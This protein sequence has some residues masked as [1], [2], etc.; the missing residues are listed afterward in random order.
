MNWRIAFA[1]ALVFAA[2]GVSYGLAI[3]GEPQSEWLWCEMIGAC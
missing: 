1:V 3:L 2:W